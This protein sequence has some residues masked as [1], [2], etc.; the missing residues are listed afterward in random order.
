[1]AFVGGS[2][3]ANDVKEIMLEVTI[4]FLKFMIFSRGV[5][6][7]ILGFKCSMTRKHLFIQVPSY[8]FLS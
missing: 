8:N 5:K 3:T 2:A 1:M 6:I 4:I 7:W